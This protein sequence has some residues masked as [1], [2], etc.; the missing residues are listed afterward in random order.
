M[1]DMNTMNVQCFYFD[2]F[3]KENT[4]QQNVDQNVQF[5]TQNIT[6]NV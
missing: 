6:K 2:Q 1:E 4:A 5:E 3:Y